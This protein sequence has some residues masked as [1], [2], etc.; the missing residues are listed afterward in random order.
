M[1]EGSREQWPGGC[2]SMSLDTPSDQTLLPWLLG[3]LYPLWGTLAKVV[4]LSRIAPG[5]LYSRN[6]W[7]GNSF[8]RSVY[9]K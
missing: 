7:N 8:F 5:S 9:Q 3:V 4:F 2:Y 6:W 1:E